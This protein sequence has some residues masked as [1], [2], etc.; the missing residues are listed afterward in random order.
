[1]ISEQRLLRMEKAADKV[2]D[3]MTVM[4]EVADVYAAIHTI[5]ELRRK[6]ERERTLEDSLRRIG[7]AMH[8][9]DLG[10]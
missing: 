10:L 9:E 7:E 8:G 5:R 4:I 3:G 6:L 1:M 2:K